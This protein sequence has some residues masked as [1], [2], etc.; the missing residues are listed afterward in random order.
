MRVCEIL[1]TEKQNFFPGSVMGPVEFSGFQRWFF[2]CC[3][4]G[5]WALDV[6]LAPV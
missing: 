3:A 6:L 2:T 5:D 4:E 1:T